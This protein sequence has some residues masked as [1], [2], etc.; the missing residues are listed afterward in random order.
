M[1]CLWL[2]WGLLLTCCAVCQKPSTMA[3]SSSNMRTCGDSSALLQT[4]A[5]EML[6]EDSFRNTCR[7]S[8]I[9]SGKCVG[10]ETCFNCN[11]NHNEKA[12]PTN[13]PRFPA[14][15][16]LC[17]GE[18]GTTCQMV[19]SDTI[20]FK[21]SG[22]YLACEGLGIC[23][24]AWNVQNAGAAC[25]VGVR[26]PT[27]GQT[28]VGT[29]ISLAVDG[30]CEHDMCCDGNQVCTQSTFTGLGSLSCR[31]HETCTN[32]T[33]E[34]Q[35]D[36][37]CNVTSIVAS[38]QSR[39]SNTCGAFGRITTSFI[40]VTG[41]PHVIDCLGNEVCRGSTFDFAS[42]SSISFECD[43]KAPGTPSFGANACRGSK[44][45]VT[46]KGDT[47]L[48]LI[49]GGSNVDSQDCRSMTISLTSSDRCFYQ[50]P[51]DN[52]PA[53]CNETNSSQ[54]GAIPRDDICCAE[55]S[56]SDSCGECCPQVTTTSTQPDITTTTT[57]KV[58]TTT[59][60]TTRKPYNYF[61][62]T[63]RTRREHRREHR[64]H[65]RQY[66][67]YSGQY[68]YD[69]QPNGQGRYDNEP[70]SRFRSGRQGIVRRSLQQWP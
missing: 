41:G 34:L 16:L 65:G 26:D 47:C 46:L 25:C 27:E 21:D 36:L 68:R 48:D 24:N 51:P 63:R 28:C 35:R 1:V 37:Y 29:T 44:T 64:R 33:A 14:G 4:T 53:Q 61:R 8:D 50:G 56:E 40:F 17:R 3:T 38:Q 67:Y 2:A 23:R 52:R 70:R 66:R 18:S 10:N 12:F 20:V 9:N 45:K 30:P 55:G 60:T 7:T 69:S 54:C 42:N 43:S 59:K 6:A 15:R 11:S 19:E 58:T 39:S 22:D 62:R 5:H 49:C 31:G 57:R 32:I 13:A